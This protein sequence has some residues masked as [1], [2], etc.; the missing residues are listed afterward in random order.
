MEEGTL[1]VAFPLLAADW[2]PCYCNF[3]VWDSIFG[4]RPK[5]SGFTSPDQ[6]EALCRVFIAD[7]LKVDDEQ[8]QEGRLPGQQR[9][10]SAILVHQIDFYWVE[11]S[12]V[13][14]YFNI[15]N[16]KWRTGK[17]KLG[18]VM[19]LQQVRQELSAN[20]AVLITNT[21]FQRGVEAYAKDKRIALY[22]LRPQFEWSGFSNKKPGLI[23]QQLRA[24]REEV[25]YFWER[26][27]AFDRKKSA[28]NGRP[29]THGTRQSSSS[30]KSRA[31]KR[32]VIRRGPKT[33]GARRH[34]KLR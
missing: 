14:E 34:P 25:Q 13:A 15:G 29:M 6:F 12:P 32:T 2:G 31:P 19:L 17:V 33:V 9:P 30:V 20:K 28:P 1:R 11:S 24:R 10:S 7:K 23:V 21:G 18:E 8:I 16:A 26:I 5:R 3:C 4:M 27:V 22:V